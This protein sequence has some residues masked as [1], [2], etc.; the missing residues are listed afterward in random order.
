[1]SLELKV[2][3]V[4]DVT[5][6]DVSG[7]VTLGEGATTLSNTIRQ[8]AVGGQKKLL[9]NLRSLTH[10]DSAGIGALVSSFASVRN[11][12][13]VLKL[14]NLSDRV[15][16]LLLITKL[17]TVFEVHNDEVTAV[18]SFHHAEASAARG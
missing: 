6:V 17:Y 10:L 18:E 7:K 11:S 12:G 14:V 1:M 3:N 15:K 13:G 8:L 2:R 16:D 5:V 4:S 9:L